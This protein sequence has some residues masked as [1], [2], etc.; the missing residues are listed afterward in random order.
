MRIPVAATF[1]LLGAAAMMTAILSAV[2]RPSEHVSV[3]VDEQ[4]RRVDISIDGQSFTSYIWPARLTRMFTGSVATG[5]RHVDKL[6]LVERNRLWMLRAARGRA[7]AGATLVWTALRYGSYL[8]H[9]GSGERCKR[10]IARA[11]RR[12]DRRGP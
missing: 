1:F 8:A 6:R 9:R 2:P 5:K 3:T 7:A 11:A 10:R 4:D 12:C